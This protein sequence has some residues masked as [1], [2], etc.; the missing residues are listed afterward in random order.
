M[1]LELMSEGNGMTFSVSV[2]LH[3]TPEGSKANVV[4]ISVWTQP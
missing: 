3:D 1:P 2:V 4:R